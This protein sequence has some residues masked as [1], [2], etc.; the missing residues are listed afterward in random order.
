MPNPS[1][2]AAFGTVRCLPPSCQPDSALRLCAHWL[3][4]LWLFVFLALG[5]HLSAQTQRQHDEEFLPG[6][7]ATFHDE[8]HSLKLI[9]P[10]PNFYLDAEESIHPS[11]S[12]DFEGEWVGVL[13]ILQTGHY[14][15]DGGPVEIHIDGKKVEEAGIELETGRHPIQIKYHRQPGRAVLRLGWKADHFPLEP[16]PQSRFSHA[17]A[18]SPDRQASLIER[19]RHLIEELGCVNCHSTDSPSLRGR[20]G[21]DLTAIGKRVSSRWLYQWLGDPSAFRSGSVMPGQ[22]DEQQRRD[23]TT[24]LLSLSSGGDFEHGRMSNERGPFFG[25]ETYSTIG[26]AACHEQPGLGLDGM[27]SKMSVEA[28]QT[29][30]KD[31]LRFDPGGRMP[32]MMLSDQ[33]AYNL[34]AM[35]TRSRDEAFE[36]PWQPGEA[37]RGRELVASS[38]CLS[39]HALQEAQ[40]KNKLLATRLDRLSPERGCLSGEPRGVPI[41]GLS[42]NDSMALRTFLRAYQANPDLSPSPI[43][44]FQRRMEQL[45]CVTCHEMEGGGPTAALAERTPSLLDAGAKLRKTWIEGIMMNGR[46]AE[47][48]TKVRMPDYDPSYVG[49]FGEAMAKRAGIQPK[50]NRSQLSLTEERQTAG[51]RLLGTGMGCIGCHGFGENEPLG[52]DGPYLTLTGERLR[53]SWFQRWMRNPARILSGTSMPNYF[54]STDPA[55]ADSTIDTLWAALS[56]GAR[57]PVPDGFPRDDTPPD[58]E[59]RPIPTDEPIVIRWSMPETTPAAVAVGLPGGV[60]YCFDAGEVRLRYAWLGGFVDMTGTLN[61]KKDRATNLTRTADLLGEIFYRS[62]EFPLR[63]G[64]IDDIPLP[65]FRG[66][67]W[68]DGHPQFHYRVGDADVYERVVAANGNQGIVRQFTISRVSGRA[69]FLTEATEDLEVTSSLGPPVDGALE[70]PEGID[71]RFSVTIVKRGVN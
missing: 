4:G 39:C 67:R 35:L 65:R 3:H 45:G 47:A 70:I 19:G 24:Y 48:K 53:Y 54:T 7:V 26:C 36:Q 9:A 15:F 23:V 52:E 25:L 63:M 58:G 11:L 68:I 6:L 32:S 10:T 64:R 62:S 30:L 16:I 57:M 27:G 34:A 40:L 56:M 49:D 5:P 50:D 22:L 13:S 60:S 61:E 69:W 42:E 17:L 12:P 33:E 66:Y 71:V 28:L 51:V 2:Q 41:Y 55:Q 1:P 8:K 43:H 29:Y 46:Q 59:A 14:Q 31:P 38:G 21:P 37:D 44:D 20:L 18:M